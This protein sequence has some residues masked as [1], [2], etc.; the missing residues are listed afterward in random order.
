MRQRMY[1]LALLLTIVDGRTRRRRQSI[2][3]T[4]MTNATFIL[5]KKVCF[6]GEV[7][8]NQ[9]LYPRCKPC[10]K[11][12]YAW[13]HVK[14]LGCPVGKFA[15]TKSH[16]CAPCERGW[17]GAGT[18]KGCHT[19][20]GGTFQNATGA[21][22]CLVEVNGV[23]ALDD[24]TTMHCPSGQFPSGVV[25]FNASNADAYGCINCS[26]GR[27]I[28]GIGFIIAGVCLLYTTA[29]CA[30]TTDK[31]QVMCMVPLAIAAF[32]WFVIIYTGF[33]CM[34]LWKWRGYSNKMRPAGLG[35][36]VG[37]I[38]FTFEMMGAIGYSPVIF[39]HVGNM[40]M[41]C[42]VQTSAVETTMA[43]WAAH[44]ETEPVV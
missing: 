1:V 31:P 6:A 38:F 39:K 40:Y 4:E 5:A 14:C 42:L 16:Q 15:P 28:S 26:P 7:L 11:N 10:R 2:H 24:G 36:I 13:R 34:C 44:T 41:W 20:S 17:A 37:Y 21:T 23:V 25:A 8:T 29:S 19:C 35:I 33:E 12:Y 32:A 3:S 22:N 43:V 27:Y 30:F 9:G 18:G